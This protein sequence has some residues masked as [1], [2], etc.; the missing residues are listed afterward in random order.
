MAKLNLAEKD[1]LNLQKAVQY[2]NLSR[3]K[4]LQFLKETDGEISWHT[5][6]RE[7]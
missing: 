5:M 3:R 6:E 7:N 4:F 2:W 1:I